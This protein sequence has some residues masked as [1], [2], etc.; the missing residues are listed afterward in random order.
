MTPEGGVTCSVAP[1][2]M[3]ASADKQSV[4]RRG[5]NGDGRIWNVTLAVAAPRSPTQPVCQGRWPDARPTA[6]LRPARHRLAWR[7]CVWTRPARPRRRQGIR[8]RSAARSRRKVCR[9]VAWKILY[10]IGS[11][12]RPIN[13]LSSDALAN[14]WSAQVQVPL[15]PAC[16]RLQCRSEAH[17]VS[18]QSSRFQRS[19]RSVER[20]AVPHSSVA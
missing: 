13:I 7:A 10:D 12:Y 2:P 6:L 1:L 20:T 18:L 4:Q 17:P 11:S 19:A 8:R 3:L 9:S 16:T 15:K 14:R 5:D